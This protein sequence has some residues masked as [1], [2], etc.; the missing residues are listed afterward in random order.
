M[1]SRLNCSRS[2]QEHYVPS[3][4]LEHF[5]DAVRF[6]VVQPCDVNDPTS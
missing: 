6:F 1:M 3:E 5:A 4:E 2:I